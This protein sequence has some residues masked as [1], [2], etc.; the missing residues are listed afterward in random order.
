MIIIELYD[1]PNIVYKHKWFTSNAKCSP[2]TTIVR[3]DTQDCG[4]IDMNYAIQEFQD[5]NENKIQ[6]I[7]R[8]KDRH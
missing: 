2:P 3:E 4:T 1:D 5:L 8:I 7:G 6:S